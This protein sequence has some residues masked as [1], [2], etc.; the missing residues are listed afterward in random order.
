MPPDHAIRTV[1]TGIL[2]GQ[3]KLI[4]FHYRL[5]T[6]EQSWLNVSLVSAFLLA[7]QRSW[8]TPIYFATHTSCEA[9]TSTVFTAPTD[10]IIWSSILRIRNHSSAL[11]QGRRLLIYDIYATAIFLRNPCAENLSLPSACGKIVCPELHLLN[12]N[13]YCFATAIEWQC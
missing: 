11:R 10:N 13:G 3:E 9:N 12:Q 4:T 8:H 2:N 6:T 5:P 7:P 1:K